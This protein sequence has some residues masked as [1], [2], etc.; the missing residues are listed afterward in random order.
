MPPQ[1][2]EQKEKRRPGS[3]LRVP[4]LPVK[5]FDWAGGDKRT[6]AVSVADTA[7]RAVGSPA[8]ADL[9]RL[10]YFNA[11][12]RAEVIRIMCAEASFHYEDYR[13]RPNIENECRQPASHADGERQC[14][15]QTHGPGNDEF[16]EFRLSGKSVTG[17]V[18]LLEVD[19]LAIV[20]TSAICRY[21]ANRF[22]MA[23]ASDAE[24]AYVDVVASTLDDL[25]IYM[26]QSMQERKVG[27]SFYTQLWPKVRRRPAACSRALTLCSVPAPVALPRPC[28][29]RRWPTSWRRWPSSTPPRRGTLWATTCPGWTSTAST[30][31]PGCRRASPRPWTATRGS[32]RSWPM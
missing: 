1:E 17:T 2:Q 32:R 16:V 14:L 20:Q 30:C 13:F 15:C 9:P 29:A 6:Q 7:A 25:Y 21:L 28:R 24:K 27:S 31:S 26:V 19:G 22:G 18:P 5:L 11:R 8:G 3:V 23:G 4:S 12:G 10:T